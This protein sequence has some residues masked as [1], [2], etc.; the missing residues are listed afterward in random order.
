MKGDH[1]IK[2]MEIVIRWETGDVCRMYS[3]RG[4][5]CKSRFRKWIGWWLICTG[6]S[7]LFGKRGWKT[8]MNRVEGE[9][10]E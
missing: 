5:S 4:K 7:A 9:E 10:D 1:E 8:Y 3:P 2:G 6:A